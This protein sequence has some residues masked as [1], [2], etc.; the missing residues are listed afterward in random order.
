MSLWP[1]WLQSMRQREM[2]DAGGINGRCQVRWAHRRSAPRDKCSRETDCRCVRWTQERRQ[3]VVK[4]LTML[5]TKYEIHDHVVLQALGYLDLLYGN[6]EYKVR[7]PLTAITAFFIA[8]KNDSG[9]STLMITD[10]IQHDI[11]LTVGDVIAE[12]F[13][14]LDALGWMLNRPTALSAMNLYLEVCRLQNEERADV[15][16][17]IEETSDKVCSLA[18]RTG[19][20]CKYLPS[21]VAAAAIVVARRITALKYAAKDM[22]EWTTNMT[23][24]LGAPPRN[25]KDCLADLGAMVRADETD[26]AQDHSRQAGQCLHASDEPPTK[27]RKLSPERADVVQVCA[28]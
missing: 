5:Q 25:L 20:S 17:E 4:L 12:E 7:E 14:A 28:A 8:T 11:T 19:V 10:L 2:L 1:E 15:T 18:I 3:K 24:A 16:K 21:T 13:R 22:E 9:G 23:N 27:Q 26:R 6:E